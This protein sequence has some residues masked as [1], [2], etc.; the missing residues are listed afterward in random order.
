MGVISSVRLYYPKSA[1]I[2]HRFATVLVGNALSI[3]HQM[4]QDFAHECVQWPGANGDSFTHA[5]YLAAGNYTL[6]VLG[7]T[8]P[9]SGKIDWSIDGVTVIAGQDWYTAGIVRNV[10]KTGAVVVAGH[11]QHVLTGLVN[12]QNG[13]SAGY[14]IYLTAL[15]LL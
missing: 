2:F 4:L 15:G 12:G 14:N 6:N 13:A 8:E 5:I 9:G 10:V 11:G 1:V 3:N 7:T